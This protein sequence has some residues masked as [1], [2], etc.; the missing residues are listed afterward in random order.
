M[1]MM[2][3]ASTLY[4]AIA[5]DKAK[6]ILK[7]ID[8]SAIYVLIAGTYTPLCLIAF[9]PVLGWLVFGFE[10]SLALTGITLQACSCR[11]LKKIE[12]A[13]YLLMGWVIVVA[14]PYLGSRIPLPAIITLIAGGIAYSLGIIW[15][16]QSHVKYAHSVWHSFVIAGAV[17]H[18]MA[19]WFV[20][21]S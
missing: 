20:L 9:P 4:H 16:R 5:H 12:L 13:V 2:F 19:V 8:H 21:T 17:C 14:A 1:V 7:K 3:L 11:F 6:P 15:Y 18:W 10:W